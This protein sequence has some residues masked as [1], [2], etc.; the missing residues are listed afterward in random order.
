MWQGAQQLCCFS[1]IALTLAG[2]CFKLALIL[3]ATVCFQVQD[4]FTQLVS[5]GQLHDSALRSSFGSCGNQEIFVS[6][7][8][9][10]AKIYF[11]LTDYI[12]GFELNG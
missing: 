5:F 1:S 9:S 3:E 10:R 12:V 11:P 2:F 8:E 6:K 4:S 7:T